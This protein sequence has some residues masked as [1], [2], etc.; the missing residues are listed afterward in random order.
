MGERHREKWKEQHIDRDEE[1]RGE[2]WKDG[3]GVRGR[4][5]EKWP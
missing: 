4:D 1:R 5:G 3:G 2:I